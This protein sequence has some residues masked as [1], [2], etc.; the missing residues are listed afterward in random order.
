MGVYKWKEGARFKADAEKVAGELL[1]LHEQTAD[2][3]LAFAEDAE[4][5]L[6][7]CATWDDSRAAHLYRLE[8]MRGVIRSVVKI[9]ESPDREPIEY[10]AFEYVIVTPEDEKPVRRF[11][12]TR[13]VLSNPEMRK[14][15]LAEIRSDIGE[16]SSKMKTYRY[17]A[18]TE[19]DA[20]QKHLDLAREAVTA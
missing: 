8:E 5:E 9:D 2:A 7:K 16:M 18:E 17:L 11:A 4:T 15:V 20:A 19:I 13:E 14:Q 6:H 1:S 12:E 3:A 10:R